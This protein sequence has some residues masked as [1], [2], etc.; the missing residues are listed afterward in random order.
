MIVVAHRGSSGTAPENTLASFL[1]AAAAGADLV[2]LDVR[3]SAECISVVLHDR[4]LRRTTDGWGQIHTTSLR[5]LQSLDAGRWYASRFAGERIPT[6]AEVFAALPGAVGVNCEVKT[7]GDPRSRLTRALSLLHTIRTHG[8]T[9]Q[10]IVSSFDHRFLAVVARHAPSLPIGLLIPPFSM[11]RLPSR[12]A[13]RT[14]AAFVFY[15]RTMLRHRTVNDAHAHGM[16][17]G[18]YCVDTLAQCVRAQRYGVDMV[19]TNYPEKLRQWIS[20]T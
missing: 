6:L 20:H 19:F 15:G 10:I 5:E 12:M 18:V 1:A 14:G 3:F 7:D 17:V 4:T 9:R 13:R 2:E 11:T 16:R 8:R